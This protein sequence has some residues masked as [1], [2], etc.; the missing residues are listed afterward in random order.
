[1]NF[2]QYTDFFQNQ[3]ETFPDGKLFRLQFD[4]TTHQLRISSR[5]RDSFEELRNAFSFENPGAF[6]S[7]QYGYRVQPKIYNINQFGYFRPGLIKEVL[8]WIKDQYSSINCLAISKN[9][10]KYIEDYLTPL[11]AFIQTHGTFKISNIADDVGRNNERRRNGQYTYDFRDYQQESIESLLF[12]G[13]GRGLIEVPTAGGKSFILAN[14]IWNLLKN[15]D[16]QM[17]FMILVPNVQ[18]V[19]QFYSD[20]LDYGFNKHELAKFTGGMSKKEKM[21]HD[22]NLAK[23]VIANRQYVFK[24]KNMLPKFDCLICDEVHQ[25]NASS[26]AELIENMDCKLK[27]GCSGTLPQ[28]KY[29][30]NN[31][32]GLFG[33]IVFKE[34]I[35]NLQNQGFISKLEITLLDI[36]D[37][38]VDKDRQLLFNLNSVN[39]FHQDDLSEGDIFFNDAFNA[40]L[41]H[42]KKFY[43][44]IYTPVLKY[45]SSIDENILVLFDKIEV[46]K[47]VFELAKQIVPSKKAHYIDGSTPVEE[48][49]HIRSELEQNGNNIL[50][51]NVAVVGTGINI[52]RLNTIV[53][54]I[55]TKSHSRI[56]QSIGRIL[57]LHSTKDVARLIDVKVNYKYSTKH[58]NERLKFYKQ[59]YKKSRPDKI[60]KLTI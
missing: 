60:V 19:A 34:Q 50:I 14:F 43:I 5:R 41:E 11:K 37:S 1:M 6:F 49:E 53:F 30:L 23:I 4:A 35:T 13:F 57:R 24:N 48:R 52:K 51:G 25:C 12:K 33:R 27:I 44:D 46:G 3:Y 45:L 55:N 40:E 31:L 59:F 58:Y 20:L 39:K 26:S 56:L 2:E 8:S 17:K 47:N 10:L 7:K 32:I 28:D 16:R 42:Y 15:V 9:C 54:L 36:F 29:Q 22:V 38:V 18:L 21:E